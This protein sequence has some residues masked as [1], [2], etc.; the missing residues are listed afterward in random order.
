MISNLLAVSQLAIAAGDVVTWIEKNL[1]IG[2]ALIYFPKIHAP[3]QPRLKPSPT[4]LHICNPR[5]CVKAKL[6]I[7]HQREGHPVRSMAEFSVC[8][9]YLITP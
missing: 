9:P 1:F 7:R 2:M 8:N 4:H 6:Q 3:S 5:H